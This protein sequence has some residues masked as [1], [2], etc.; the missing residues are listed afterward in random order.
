M[1]IQGQAICELQL[2]I[3]K[4]YIIYGDLHENYIFSNICTRSGLA[5]NHRDLEYLKYKK[6]GGLKNFVKWTAISISRLV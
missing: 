5:E 6:L 1:I 3:G 4:S 2:E